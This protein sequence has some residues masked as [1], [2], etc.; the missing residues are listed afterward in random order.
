MTGLPFLQLPFSV[1]ALMAMITLPIP[2]I[3]LDILFTFNIALS[4]LVLL[5]SIY[6]LRPLDFTNNVVIADDN[7]T[8]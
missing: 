8:K 6:S 7:F 3:L 5:V 4:L 2:P 1:L